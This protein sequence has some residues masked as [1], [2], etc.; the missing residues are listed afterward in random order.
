VSQCQSDK[1]TMN[2][3]LETEAAAAAVQNS[4][5]AH[6][7]CCCNSFSYLA[8]SPVLLFHLGC[9]VRGC[10]VLFGFGFWGGHQTLIFQRKFTFELQRMY[11]RCI[12]Y[13]EFGCSG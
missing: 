1:N 6:H 9:C 7:V 10:V 12:E 13:R 2:E 4:Q 11:R 8:P 5:T 3:P